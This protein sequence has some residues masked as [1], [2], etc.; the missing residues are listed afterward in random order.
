MK[1]HLF[2]LTVDN[3][4]KSNLIPNKDYSKNKLITGMLQLPDNFHLIVDE[5]ALNTG[6]LNA[7]GLMNF[8]SIKDIVTY[9][10]LNYDFNYHHQEFPTNIRVLILSQTKS[11]L[12]VKKTFCFK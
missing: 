7:K 6:E 12:P 2:E 8:N 1:A 5:T 9:Q 4:N 3:L 10:K 11:I